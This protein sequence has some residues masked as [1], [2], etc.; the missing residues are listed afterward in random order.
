MGAVTDV[1]SRRVPNLLTGPA[2]LAGLAL[3]S[4]LDGWR[5]LEHS[6]LGALICGG[7]FFVLFLTGG[8]GGGDVKL[9]AA[10]GALAGLSH[11]VYVLI[12]TGLAGGV[13]A[14]AL[15]ARRRRFRETLT[16]VGALVTHHRIHGLEPHPEINV[17]NAAALRLPYALAIAAGTAITL[18]LA[19]T[20]R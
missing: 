6:F 12:F 2:I 7:I 17:T 20:Q 10:V 14:L 18:C 5:G 1:K 9:I 3:H 8:M 19:A 13:M 11:I 16:N 15:V 4:A